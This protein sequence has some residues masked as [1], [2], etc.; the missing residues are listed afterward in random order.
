MPK[1]REF[2]ATHWDEI[3][4]EIN[5]VVDE[6]HLPPMATEM[7]EYQLQSGGKR[8]RPVLAMMVED[9]YRGEVSRVVPF[10][11][12]VELIHNASLVHDDLQDEDEMRRDRAT[13]WSAFSPP[14]AISLGDL[15]FTM[16]FKLFSRLDASIEKKFA[17]TQL[18]LDCV[19]ALAIGQML[20]FHL[21]ATGT[22]TEPDYLS[23]A[24]NKTASLFQ[25]VFRGAGELASAPAEDLGE[26]DQLGRLLGLL[27]QI[28]DDVIDVAGFKEGRGAGG[29]I[30]EGKITLMAAHFL[31]GPAS[32]PMRREVAEILG[33]PKA[34]TA[35]EDVERVAQL[36]LE[37][38]SISHCVEKLDELEVAIRNM[39]ILERRPRLGAGMAEMLGHLRQGVP[40]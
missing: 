1:L 2:L 5:A 4:A 26:L 39:P 36:Y 17:V 32:E 40:R 19:A 15:V 35:G 25:L 21:K 16:G 22:Y 14:H 13:I 37:Y 27:F 34:E 11:A 18:G 38:G 12:A 29:D 23:V 10:A 9:A 30:A 3:A 20:E 6:F 31:A 24:E 33:H 7:V 8:I 28:R